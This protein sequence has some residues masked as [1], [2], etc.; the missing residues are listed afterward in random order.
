HHQQRAKKRQSVKRKCR[1]GGAVDGY[2]ERGCFESR[3]EISRPCVL[4]RDRLRYPGTRTR[5]GEREQCYLGYRIGKAAFAPP[6]SAPGRKR[7]YHRRLQEKT[8]ITSGPKQ[9]LKLHPRR[10][11]P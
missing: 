3:T 6:R 7:L 5:N 8:R 11:G 2:A 10:P 1:C 9:H 4:G